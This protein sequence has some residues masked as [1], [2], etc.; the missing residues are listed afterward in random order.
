MSKRLAV[1][2]WIKQHEIQIRKEYAEYAKRWDYHPAG[3]KAFEWFAQR[4]YEEML[5]EMELDTK[6]GP[7]NE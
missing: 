1:M 5:N 3:P 2:A 6:N 7:D 4:E